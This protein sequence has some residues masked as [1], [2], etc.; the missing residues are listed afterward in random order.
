VALRVF[1]M[2]DEDAADALREALLS[3]GLPT[4]GS[5][6]EL[7]ERLVDAIAAE[8]E[9]VA[10]D[11]NGMSI[12]EL[13]ELITK[14]RLS[15]DDCLDKTDLR[16]RA[17]QAAA[18]LA[19]TR[20]AHQPMFAEKASPSEPSCRPPAAA[21]AV[22][23]PDT[24]PDAT[25]AEQISQLSLKDLRGLIHEAGLSPDG[26]TDKAELRER[27]CEAL[28]RL[29][30]PGAK[31]GPIAKPLLAE[32][33][34]RAEAAAAAAKL[35][36]AKARVVAEAEV[37]RERAEAAAVERAAAETAAAAKKAREKEKRKEKKGRKKEN[38]A[39]AQAAGEN[40]AAAA[41]D[42]DDDDDQDEPLEEEDDDLLLRLAASRLHSTPSADA[43]QQPPTI[44]TEPDALDVTDGSQADG[45]DAPGATAK[46][47][48]PGW[49]MEAG[50]LVE[51]SESVPAKKAKAKK[52]K[53]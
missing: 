20:T 29:M 33:A 43:L 32:V 40:G 13:K 22:A 36:A 24:A 45:N 23:Q 9:T 44:T 48:P 50:L 49:R 17:T 53:R 42:D 47:L 8:Q 21:P 14:A 5:F 37:Q 25:I 46:A 26:C 7:E 1:F 38:K 11:V 27:A 52:N 2:S 16:A 30:L 18:A 39:K 35:E 19:A 41:D 4:H 12:K 34:S 3:R 31:C 28:E 15:Y 51:G 10:E 6:A